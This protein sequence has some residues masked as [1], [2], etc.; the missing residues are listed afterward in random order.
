ME[1]DISIVGLD[2]LT[3]PSVKNMISIKI[4]SAPGTVSVPECRQRPV[5][6]L[7]LPNVTFNLCE[8]LWNKTYTSH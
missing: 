2:A 7:I 8:N 1:V 5:K 4:G 6:A 3:D